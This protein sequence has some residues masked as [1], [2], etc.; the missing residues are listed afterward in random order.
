MKTRMKPLAIACC[1]ALTSPAF[2]APEIEQI[3]VLGQTG[4]ASKS[5]AAQ[6]QANNLITVASS[7][8]IGDF[9]D[10]NASES[11]QRLVGLSI[12]RDQGEGRF[13]RVRGLAPDY[14]AVTINGARVPAPEAGRRA[15]ALDVVPSDLVQSLTVTK[16][17]T[18]DMDADS[19]GGAIDI[20]SSSAFDRDGEFFKFSSE[21]GYNA[22]QDEFSPSLS[23]AYSN[24]FADETFGVAVAGSFVERKFGSDNV[25]TGGG[26]D[27]DDAARMVDLEQRDYVITRERQGLAANLDWRPSETQQ[28][29]LRGLYSEF[30]DDEQRNAVVVEWEDGVDVNGSTAEAA[31]ARELKQ[32]KET[33]TIQSLSLGLDQQMGQ[34][35]LGVMLGWGQSEED[36]PDH[37]ESAFEYDGDLPLSVTGSEK[38]LLAGDRFDYAGYELDGIEVSETFTSDQ[39]QSLR[40]DL[41]RHFELA[42]GELSVKFGAKA[43]RRDKEN[44]ASFWA[45]EDLDDAG[46]A[47][48]DLLLSAYL[49]AEAD[50][51]LGDFGATTNLQSIRA[52]VDQVGLAGYE[53]DV[54]STLGDF[55]MTEDIDAGYVML[56]AN[57]GELTLIG[58]ARVEATRFSASGWRYDD[59]AGEFSPRAEDHEYTNTLPSLIARYDLDQDTVVRAAFTTSLVRPTFEQAA[60]G[61]LLEED[62][63]DVEAEFG[64]PTLEPLTANNFDLGI[65]HYMGRLGLLS[66]GLFYKDI[67]NFIYSTDIAGAV[68]FEDYAKAVTYVN[69]DSAE[70]YGLE[71]ALVKQFDSLSYP[72]NGLLVSANATFTD[73]EASIQYFDDGEA[74]NRAID[75]PSQSAQTGN[76]ALGYQDETFN[77]RLSAAYKSSYLLEVG[78]LDD[79]DYDVYEDDHLQLDLIAKVHVNKQLMLYFNALNLTNQAY[80]TYVNQPRFNAQY[81][82]YGRSFQLGFSYSGF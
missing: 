61:M 27:F 34:W 12:E 57:L 4:S 75:F 71:L 73:A 74:F 14:N 9:P 49:G 30:S 65:E 63:G 17:L 80:Y 10:A 24:L 37:I 51:G 58:G 64:N 15:V 66:A 52:L 44:D 11:L 31:V 35:E 62:D 3:L 53:D 28:W 18:P 26:W 22:L 39:D 82:E 72:W 43:S 81:E 54:E 36:T 50:Y 20:K 76:L 77:L 40:L 23:A 8:A 29:F 38:P 78:E 1:W 19:L 48:Q 46:V 47:E 2:A 45:L 16:S 13:V 6:R 42:D 67:D 32:R 69:G 7:D 68:D 79:P 70:L 33:Q 21:A 25:E 5:L 56:T 55:T 59:A 60:P 41:T